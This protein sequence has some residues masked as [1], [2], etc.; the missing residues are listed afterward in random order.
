[1]SRWCLEQVRAGAARVGRTL[2]RF[3]VITQ[4]SILF[5]P[6]TPERQRRWDG[7]MTFYINHCVYPEFDRLWEVSGLREEALAVRA[8]AEAGDRAR[9]ERLMVETIYPHLVVSGGQRDTAASFWQWLDGH[10]EAG[11]TMIGLP[12]EIAETVGISLDE[13][14]AHVAN[15]PIRLPAE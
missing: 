6:T 12:L 3:E 1:M 14:K 7:A 10:L 9:A 8:A 5:E 15:R 11:V 4:P 2:N 13:V